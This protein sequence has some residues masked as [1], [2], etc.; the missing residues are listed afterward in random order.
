MAILV[1]VFELT[2][3]F[4]DKNHDIE[5]AQRFLAI[6]KYDKAVDV[7]EKLLSR[8]P[9]DSDVQ[10]MLRQA[11]IGAKEYDKLSSLL[12]SLLLKNPDNAA[13]WIE[14]GGVYL[15][16]NKP[17]DAWKSFERAISLKPKD[18]VIIENIHNLLQQWSFIDDDIKF[19]KKSR[20]RLG[21]ENLFA[22]ELAR[23]YEI[24]GKFDKVIEEYSRYLKEHPDRFSE[25]EHR[26]S[27]S[28]RTPDEL[29]QLRKSLNSLFD[30]QV[31][32]W[33]PW[34]LI[35]IVEQKLGNYE[36]AFDDM[37]KAEN[38]R[39]ERHRGMLMASFVR[40]MLT[41]K[42]FSIAEK[43]ARYIIS[44]TG[45]NYSRTGRLYLARAL[46]GLG[47]Y[48]NALAELDTLMMAKIPPISQD[49]A[50]FMSQIL[51]ENLHNPDSAQKVID[52]YSE[53]ANGKNILGEDGLVIQ[54]LIYIY[55]RQFSK[56]KYFLS[57]AFKNNNNS[58][59][60]AYLLGMTYFFSG[61]YDT[62]ST[63]LHNI[64]AKFPKSPLGNESVELLLIM[65]TAKDELNKLNKPLYLMFIHDTLSAEKEWEN[66]S[67]KSNSAISD[68]ILWKLG[69]CQLALGND[70]GFVTM[71]KLYTRFP[72]SFYA[73]LA[74]E[75]LADRDMQVGNIPSAVELYTK[76]INDYPD[77]VNI[78][79]VRDK[80]KKLG[81]L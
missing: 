40:E 38:S 12:Q 60:L 19:L 42:E 81:N 66:I 26:I 11:Y 76:I 62:A 55:K 50:I 51:L 44:N 65:Q 43:G 27:V 2:A 24:Q 53:T 25:V 22:L 49:A 63:A 15:S 77:A 47:K 33:Q 4:A 73:P 56:A 6:E 9:D 30:A 80:L 71:E 20:K 74:L 67:G 79:G 8:Y 5:L 48:N 64:V 45:I 31:P 18:I 3:V 41:A 78:E 36:K 58:Q 1:C 46:R 68:Y 16:Q 29:R 23:L 39:D 70:T 75:K 13:L 57:N 28:Q 37:V 17:D 32:E 61:S 21:D 34:R 72:K 54:G 52:N 7:L 59:R 69:I 35:S 14:L 10:Y